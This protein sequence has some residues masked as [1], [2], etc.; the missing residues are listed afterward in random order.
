MW[1]AGGACSVADLRLPPLDRPASELADLLA[2]LRRP[3]VVIHPGAAAGS[4][5]WPA[6]RWA[7]VA[8]LLAADGEGVVVTGGTDERDLCQQVAAAHEAVTDLGGRLDLRD[9]AALVGRARLLLSGDTG[10]AHLATSYGT[11]SVL[12]FGPTP[13]DQWGPRIDPD[14]HDV[15]WRPHPDDPA[16]DPHGRATDV[17][18]ERIPVEAVVTR[19]RAQLARTSRSPLAGTRARGPSRS[20]DQTLGR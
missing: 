14:L 2:D 6:D 4:R 17:R 11:P 1:A 20:A 15:I 13:P 7:A 18:L 3:P 9:L 5:R 16:G 19:A 10:V 8:T 12:L